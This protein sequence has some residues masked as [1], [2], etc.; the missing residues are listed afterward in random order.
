MVYISVI[1]THIRWGSEY[2]T[3]LVFKWLKVV[4]SPNGP[5]AIWILDIWMPDKWTPQ[6]LHVMAHRPLCK[7]L[8]SPQILWSGIGTV[9]N[10]AIIEW[11]FNPW[12]EYLTKSPL[13]RH[14]FTYN[15]TLGSKY[16]TFSPVFMSPPCQFYNTG[17]TYFKPK[18]YHAQLVCS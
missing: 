4:R 3:S 17:F 14:F 1:N 10:S 16:Q 11:L 5:N 18:L 12:P 8:H 9:K 7:A 15:F 2:R 13:F 6:F